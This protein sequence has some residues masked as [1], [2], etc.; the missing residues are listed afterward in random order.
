MTGLARRFVVRMIIPPIR[1]VPS[2]TVKAT[3]AEGR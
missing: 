2:L 3:Q 1:A